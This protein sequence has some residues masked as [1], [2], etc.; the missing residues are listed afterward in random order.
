[1]GRAVVASFNRAKAREI[2]EILAAEGL[3]L[4][5]VPLSDFPGVSLPAETGRTFAEN[6]LA[7]ARAASRATG[8]PALADDSGLEVDALGGQPGVMSARYAGEGAR[9]EARYRKVLG[10]L[11]YVPEQQRTARF[12][13][14]AAFVSP[15][16]AELLAAGTCEGR[17]AREPAGAGGFGYDPIFIPDGHTVTMAQLTAAQKHAISHRGRAFRA[18]ARRM[19][20]G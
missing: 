16:G 7:K 20:E 3:Q 14:A 19:R 1:M 13:C 6:A 11:T 12:H 4:E 2:A 8:L 5:V 18:L 17:I 10:L 9:D 15:E